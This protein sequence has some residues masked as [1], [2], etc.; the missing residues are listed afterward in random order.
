MCNSSITASKW[1]LSHNRKVDCFHVTPKRFSGK[2]PIL[3]TAPATCSAN[4]CQK[5]GDLGH[6][7]KPPNVGYGSWF[8]G[9]ADGTHH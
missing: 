1:P 9:Q 4:T 5:A 2:C 6:A 3:F 7:L 8:S